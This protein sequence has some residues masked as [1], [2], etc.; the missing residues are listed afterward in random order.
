MTVA[1]QELYG[2]GRHAVATRGLVEGCWEAFAV[3]LYKYLGNQNFSEVQTALEVCRRQSPQDLPVPRANRIWQQ[4]RHM[5][6]PCDS[7]LV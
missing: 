3:S 7:I 4:R 5:I 1:S 6:A 2:V